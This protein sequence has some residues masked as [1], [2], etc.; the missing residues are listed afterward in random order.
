VR[1]AVVAAF[2]LV[3]VF[4]GGCGSPGGTGSTTGG[5]FTATQQHNLDELNRYRNAAGLRTLVLDGKLNQ[6]AQAGTEALANGGAPHGHFEAASQNGSL[7]SSGFCN[8][9]G[10]NQ[11]PG[12]PLAPDENGALD[13]I[14]SDMMAEQ[15]PNDGHRK[16]ILD[17]RWGIVGVGV[18]V[19]NGRLWMTN[20]FSPPCP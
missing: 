3:T 9:A 11:A 1:G 4:L 2:A 12:W 10:E 20:D 15:P 7:F 16:N 5:T 13:D 18:V 19:R 8:A 17:A 14:L 6:F